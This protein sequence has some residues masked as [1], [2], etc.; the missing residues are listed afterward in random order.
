MSEETEQSLDEIAKDW[1][2]R[3]EQCVRQRNYEEA[4][5]MLHSR[6]TYFGI[7]F[8]MPKSDWESVWPGQLNFTFDMEST[9]FIAEP[10]IIVMIT[11]WVA[12]GLL[13]GTLPKHGR[14]TI[15]LIK[16]SNGKVLAVHMHI[17][18]QP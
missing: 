11:N 8:D 9:K 18:R 15:G 7:E 14:A 3:F 5:A 16:F 10:G 13:H 17:S 2:Y 12:H 1:L 4:G 6:C